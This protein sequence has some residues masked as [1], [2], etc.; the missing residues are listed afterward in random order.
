MIDQGRFEL[1]GNESDKSHFRAPTLRNIALTSPYMHDG[2]FKTLDEVLRHYN[3]GGKAYP[4]K[5]PLLR[6]L[7][8]TNEQIDAIIAFLRSLTDDSFI[9]DTTLSDPW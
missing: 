1:T 9:R 5:D 4:T 3:S 8:L 2:R 7:G 6:P